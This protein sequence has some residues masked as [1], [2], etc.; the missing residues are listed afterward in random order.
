MQTFARPEGSFDLVVVGGGIVGSAT[1]ALAARAGLRVALLERLDFGSGASSASSK[2]IHGGLRYLRMGDVRLV[3][4]GLAEA[5]VLRRVV[6]PYLVRELE[7]VLPVYEGGPHGRFAVRAA[8]GAYGLL[9]GRRARVV[10]AERAAALAPHLRREG[11]VAAGVYADAQTNDAR[12][13]LANVR[14]AADAGD[15]SR[16]QHTVFRENRQTKRLKS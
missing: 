11:L 16:A 15:C 6:A 13:T 5:R 3:R 10:S 7:F 4:E 8:L 2:L 1:A 9:G 14:A 12:L